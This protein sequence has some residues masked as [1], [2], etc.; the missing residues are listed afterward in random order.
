MGFRIQGLKVMVQGFS[1]L[2]GLGV[3]V[4]V[5]GSLGFILKVFKEFLNPVLVL[6][7]VRS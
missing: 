4:R 1:Y 5:W 7:K 2:R 6:V 3:I